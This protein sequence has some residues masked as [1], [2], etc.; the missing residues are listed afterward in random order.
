MRAK[1]VIVGGG[2]MGLSIA[3]RVARRTDPLVE[4]VLLLERDEP[5]AGASGRSSAV[6]RQYYGSR[7]TAGM[8]RDSLRYY[9]GFENRT[10]RSIGFVRTG[11]LTLALSR[12]PEDVARLEE[13]VEMQ[14]SIGIEVSVVNAAE[15]RELVH[16]IE[17]ED[18]TFG[19]WECGA[20]CVDAERTL[21]AFTAIA[22]N[23]GAVIR[24]GARV[25]EVLV[26][27]GRVRG[28][29]T[30]EDVVECEQ[31]VLA[32]GAWTKGLLA[33]LGLDYP[34][35]VTST[36]HLFV[37][38]RDPHLAQGHDDPKFGMHGPEDSGRPPG[39]RATPCTPP[40]RTPTSKGT[41]TISSKA[42]GRASRTRC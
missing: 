3:S 39:S 40:W 13:L 6:L 20:G 35:E 12:A 9:A 29:R 5:G 11:V 7:C 36:A 26:E 4:P 32:A 10:G 22:R 18:G 8:A 38:S 42:R 34:L 41:T 33:R 28:V 15:I 16:G 14:A 21:E 17:I 30:A 19:A 2:V 23:K 25:E 24:N 31:V 1:V 37:C 27:G